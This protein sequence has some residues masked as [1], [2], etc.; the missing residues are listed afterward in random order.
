MLPLAICRSTPGEGRKEGANL[1]HIISPTDTVQLEGIV[2]DGGKGGDEFNKPQQ[3]IQAYTKTSVIS[4]NFPVIVSPQPSSYR[5]P[6]SSS[7]RGHQLFPNTQ[8]P[9]FQISFLGCEGGSRGS[10]ACCTSM[11]TSAGNPSMQVKA[12]A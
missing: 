1:P 10:S 9:Q 11:R 6:T 7:L 5:T 2:E 12:A 4:F 8:Q 3:C